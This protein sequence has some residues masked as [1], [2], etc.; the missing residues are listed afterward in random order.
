MT[1]L[2]TVAMAQSSAPTAKAVEL[3]AETTEVDLT[4]KAFKQSTL[5]KLKPFDGDGAKSKLEVDIA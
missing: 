5:C 4:E 3:G 2:Q 1:L